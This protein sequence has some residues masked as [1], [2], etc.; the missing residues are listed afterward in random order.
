MNSSDPLLAA[1]QDCK[2]FS[3][4]RLGLASLMD[5]DRGAVQGFQVDGMAPLVPGGWGSR[6]LGSSYHDC[7]YISPV[8]LGLARAVPLTE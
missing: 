6:H 4:P 5:L 2:L 1:P 7:E 8:L 3:G